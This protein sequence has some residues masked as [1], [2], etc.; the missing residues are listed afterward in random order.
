[1]AKGG[2]GVVKVEHQA[3]DESPE[4]IEYGKV[5]ATRNAKRFSGSRKKDEIRRDVDE[6]RVVGAEFALGPPISLLDLLSEGIQHFR[7]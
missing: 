6:N 4:H 7:K 3:P 1:L 5:L 2:L